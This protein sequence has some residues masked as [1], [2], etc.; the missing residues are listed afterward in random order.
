MIA[1][2][3]SRDNY[4]NVYGLYTNQCTYRI[5]RNV[6]ILHNLR[7]YDSGIQTR[8]AIKCNVVCCLQ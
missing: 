2:D 5:E 6:S 4:G 7:D 1:K 3:G 8:V